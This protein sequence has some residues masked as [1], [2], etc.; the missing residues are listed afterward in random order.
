M[1]FMVMVKATRIPRRQAALGGVCS[2]HGEVQRGDGE[3]RRNARW[4]WVE[5]SPK[6]RAA[7]SGA[8]AWSSTGP[9]P[10]PATGRG[11]LESAGEIE[12]EAIEWASSAAPIPRGRQRHQI[13]QLFELE[14]FGTSEA[15]EHHR[16]SGQGDEEEAKGCGGTGPGERGRGQQWLARPGISRRRAYGSMRG[17]LRVGDV[18]A[19]SVG[20]DDGNETHRHRRIC[21]I[22]QASSSPGTGTDGARRRPAEELAQDALSPARASWPRSG[23]PDKRALADGRRQASGH[24][25]AAAQRAD[26]AQDAGAGPRKSRRRTGRCAPDLDGLDRRFGGDDL[27]RLVFIA[28]SID[29]LATEALRSTLRLIGG[30]TTEEIARAFLCR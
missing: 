13:R 9:F 7:F 10:K 12:A 17:G 3:G 25:P 8:S 29:L 5:P 16:R 27:L 22:E 1:R 26:R 24:R 28:W 23:V 19:Q 2:S 20:S 4:Q 18:D 14:D 30:L 6:A 21:R 11:D 15:V